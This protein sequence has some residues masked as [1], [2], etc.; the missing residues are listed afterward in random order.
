MIVSLLP[1]VLSQNQIKSTC[2]SIGTWNGGGCCTRTNVAN[3]KWPLTITNYPGTQCNG[4]LGVD[5]SA[6]KLLWH[7]WG[8]NQ[9]YTILS[10]E[11]E[12]KKKQN[13]IKTTC[14]LYFSMM[15][16]RGRKPQVCKGP[17]LPSGIKP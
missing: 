8:S 12:D 6:H 15:P 7:D 3:F 9:D 16:S 5:R 1:N 4:N 11:R 10:A 2:N 13:K 14:E 17:Y